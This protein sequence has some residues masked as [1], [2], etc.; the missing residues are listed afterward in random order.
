MPDLIVLDLGLPDIEVTEVCRRIRTTSNVPIVVLSARGA[1]ADKVHALDLGADDYVTKPFGP[2]KL[3]ARIRVALRRVASNEDDKT[4]SFRAAMHDR[5]RPASRCERGCRDQADAEGIRASVTAR[6][7]PRSRPDAPRH[8]QGRMGTERRRA[9]RAPV[10]AGR[11]AAEE[12][13]PD[14]ANPR[15]LLSEPWVG[16]RFATLQEGGPHGP[17]NQPE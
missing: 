16:Y 12:I 17:T 11:S 14:P 8:S 10:D 1:E 13:Q 15:F 5:L 4:G 7:E 3:L 6:A 9:T 2:E